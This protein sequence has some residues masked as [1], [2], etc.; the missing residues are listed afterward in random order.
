MQARQALALMLLALMATTLGAAGAA[1]QSYPTRPIRFIIP[2]APGGG[3]DLIG[4]IVGQKLSEALGKPVIVDN[5]AGA[6]GIV[7]SELGARAAPDGYTL[8]MGNNSTLSISQAMN[9]KLSYDST[10]DF[11]PISTLVTSPHLLIAGNAVPAKTLKEFIA[12]AKASRGSSTSDRPARRLILPLSCSD[13]PPA[14][15]WCTYRTTV[16]PR[17]C[18]R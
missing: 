11:A 14:C 3:L 13:T 7:G 1:E 4:R 18:S 8:T 17:C 9:S 5:R 15:S 16:R 12:L 2:Y 10:R 6:G